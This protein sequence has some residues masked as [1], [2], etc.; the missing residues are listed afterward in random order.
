MFG[1][2]FTITVF[3]CKMLIVFCDHLIRNKQCLVLLLG[4][5]IYFLKTRRSSKSVM[6]S[7]NLACAQYSTNE[8]IPGGGIWGTNN[9]EWLFRSM[10]IKSSDLIL[11]FV[12]CGNISNGRCNLHPYITIALRM[13]LPIYHMLWYNMLNVNFI[14]VSRCNL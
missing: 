11:M 9:R 7:F 4:L 5:L 2:E 13:L 10:A 6:Y 8:A 12:T 14:Y 1:A 3:L